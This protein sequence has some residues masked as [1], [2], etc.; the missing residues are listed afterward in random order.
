MES[1]KTRAALLST[2]VLLVI[3]SACQIP[4]YTP[5]DGTDLELKAKRADSYETDARLST[6][7]RVRAN[8][9]IEAAQ[10]HIELEQFQEAVRCLSA[11]RQAYY[12][13][14]TAG[15]TNR[16]LGQAYLE[17][18]ETLLAERYLLKGLERAAGEVRQQTLAR[19]SICARARGDR[20]LA[21]SYRRRLMKPHSP[22]VSEIF[23]KKIEVDFPRKG[24]FAL[25]DALA[26]RERRVQRPRT[27][28]SMAP[29]LHHGGVRWLPRWRWKARPIQANI[30]PMRQIRR[31]TIHHTGPPKPFW[32]HSY[33]DVAKEIRRIQLF[34]QRDRGWA[35]IGYHFLL[36]RRGN[37]WQGRPLR[38]QGAH[39]GG[40]A[41]RGN[42]GVV[43]LGDYTRQKLTSHQRRNLTLLIADLTRRYSVPYAKVFTHSEIMGG[44]TVC[45]GP[46]IS[47]F[48]A[49]LRRRLKGR[50][51]LAYR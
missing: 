46:E 28:D 24:S 40:S 10:L 32:G 43:V 2:C 1:S 15:R 8:R 18:G 22:A 33:S 16:L 48:V 36:D 41:N 27:R 34:H 45:P 42:I 7:P 5:E 11:A 13:G 25:S 23:R 19:L 20:V 29:A 17:T 4:V 3:A 21:D 30:K 35:D 38:Y 47:E 39:A 14:D 50:N 51:I 12:A 31:I 9:Y 26:N 6:R 49:L 37:V 44:G